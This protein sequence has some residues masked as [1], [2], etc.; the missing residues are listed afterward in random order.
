MSA[1]RTVAVGD[2]ASFWEPFTGQG[3]AWALAGSRDLAPVAT[4]LVERWDPTVATEWER[5]TRGRIAEQE[6][7]S[8]RV[9]AVLQH[10]MRARVALWALRRRPALIDRW[11][12]D[13]RL[14]SLAAAG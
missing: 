11:L 5:R 9:G 3:I 8:R 10:P 14:V 7:H 2:A 4:R 6:A 12:P 1:E 13:Q